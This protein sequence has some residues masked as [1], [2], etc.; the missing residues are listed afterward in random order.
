MYIFVGTKLCPP[1]NKRSFEVE[2]DEYHRR[3]Q[4]DNL[5]ICTERCTCL[6]ARQWIDVLLCGV[7]V[8]T[9][10]IKIGTVKYYI[11][12]TRY[13]RFAFSATISLITEYRATQFTILWY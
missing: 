4:G 9:T 10:V 13:L 6:Q 7:K 5:Q 1:R 12:I 8:V 3:L 2:E 11:A